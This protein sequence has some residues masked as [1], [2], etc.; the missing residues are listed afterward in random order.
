M[1]K[2]CSRAWVAWAAAVALAGAAGA[3]SS[4]LLP[5][6]GAP[7]DFF[8]RAVAVSGTT[9]VV[10]A[11]G[12]DG[13]TGAAYV[14]DAVTGAELGTL[15]ANDGVAG[16]RFGVS[17][18]ISGALVLVGADGDTEHG[19]FSGSAYVF[20]ANTGVQLHKLVP[21]D[22]AADDYFGF[23]VALSGTTAV[24]GAFGDDDQGSFAG[25]VYLF[26]ASTGAEL[27]KLYAS[28]AAIDD[29][30]GYSVAVS[31]TTALVG[32]FGND[33][34][35]SLSGAAYLIDTAAELEIGKLLPADDAQNEFG[36][37]VAIDGTTALIGAWYDDDHGI[38]AGAAY[39]FDTLSQTQVVKLTTADAATLDYVGF[40]VAV[41]GGTALL[42]GHGNDDNGL[43]SG[44][45][46]L[47]DTTTGAELDKLL[48][49]DGAAGDTFGAAVGLA[50]TVAIVGAHLDS[51]NGAGSG[52]A[53]LF[54]APAV[55]Y[56]TAGVSTNGCQ[57]LLSASGTPSA[58]AATGFTL[59]AT[60]VEG[61]K[62]GLFFFGPNGRQANS[63]GNGTSFQ[64]VTPP[65][66]RAGLLAGT[67]SSGACDGAL[68]Q[69]LNARWTAKPNQ[70]PGVGAVV[71]AQL[72]Y[73]DPQNTSNQTTSL[74]DALEFCVG[75]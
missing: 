28:D 57:A 30:F 14:F 55:S 34:N 75:P 40:A 64:C 43:G 74:S 31:G 26:D 41:S 66:M 25:A 24:V 63:W 45:A 52:S 37:S 47:F 69:D 60:G 42:S 8:G 6:G 27:A 53:Y 22:G 73:R 4:K 2:I 61:A 67:G 50:G 46:Y 59:I 18:A 3:E 71:Q 39:V 21:A 13:G 38:D 11:R 9:A 12:D 29:Y 68:A 23:A 20:D 16:D 49:S 19:S 5:A 51:D 10:G 7:G 36:V 56:C 33:D 54:C 1:N 62:D 15:S 32:A 44:S 65:V 17:V 58:S 35:G 70:N 48:P 72:W